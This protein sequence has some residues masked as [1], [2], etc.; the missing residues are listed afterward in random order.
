MS[1]ILPAKAIATIKTYQPF[2]EPTEVERRTQGLAVIGYID[3]ADKHRALTLVSP[4]LVRA[5]SITKA[6]GRV[7]EQ[8]G[9]LPCRKLYR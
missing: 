3:N 1:S 9:K 8:A 7:L 2:T 6:R 4:G 5:T